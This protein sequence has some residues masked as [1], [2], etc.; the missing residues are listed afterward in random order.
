MNRIEVNEKKLSIILFVI[1]AV[2]YFL[3]YFG[4][5]NLISDNL[6]KVSINA[7]NIIE[8]FVIAFFVLSV[9]PC[10]FGLKKLAT[11]FLEK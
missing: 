10:S 1:S 7:L 6:L 11:K 8:L 3:L 9:V 5:Y 2:V 4:I